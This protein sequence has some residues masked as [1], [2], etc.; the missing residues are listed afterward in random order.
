[1][2]LAHILAGDNSCRRGA[3]GFPSLALD[4]HALDTLREQIQSPLQK[5]RRPLGYELVIGIFLED[6]PAGQPLVQVDKNEPGLHMAIWEFG[7]G[8][9]Q[10]FGWCCHGHFGV[11]GA[12]GAK[13][14]VS[15]KCLLIN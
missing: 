2:I 3:L 10:A 11:P 8:L 14:T 1:M 5:Y 12:I 4:T 7:Q 6:A 13:F 15:S 9:G